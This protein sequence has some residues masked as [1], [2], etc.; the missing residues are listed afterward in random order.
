M[1]I[2]RI[3]RKSSRNLYFSL[4]SMVNVWDGHPATRMALRPLELGDSFILPGLDFGGGAAPTWVYSG[5]P[6]QNGKCPMSV[7]NRSFLCRNCSSHAMYRS[8]RKGLLE[9]ILHSVLFISPYRCKGAISGTSGC[10][11]QCIKR[12][13]RHTIRRSLFA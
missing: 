12:R 10:A 11:C 7:L 3:G 6:S 5:G 9:H 1:I 8:K 4:R 13:K 2:N